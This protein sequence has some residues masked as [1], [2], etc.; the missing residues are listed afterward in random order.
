MSR[1]SLALILTAVLTLVVRDARM[2]AA[3][4][5]TPVPAQARVSVELDQKEFF[6][7]EN[8]LLHFCIENVGTEPFSISL[9][10]DYRG[11]SRSL[12][13]QVQALDAQG[14]PCD[15]PDP[16][17]FC[18]GGL[19]HS[20]TV[21]PGKKHY[22]SIP[23]L[24]YR[25]IEKPGVYTIRVSHDLGWS[26]TPARKVP[27]AETKITFVKPTDEQA[28]KL[29][30]AMLKT[31]ANNGRT[32][33]ER[34]APYPDFSVLRDPV[35]LPV[36]LERAREKSEK[37]LAGIGSI[38]TP[39]A[40]EALIQLAGHEDPAF[41]LSAAQTLDMRLPDPQLFGELPGR[42]PFFNDYLAPRRWL[43]E[44]SWRPRMADDVAD[45]ARKFLAREDRHG[46]EC[47]GYMLQCCGRKEDLPHLVRTLDREIAAAAKRPLE[48]GIYP[49]PRGACGELLRAARMLGAR[50]VPAPA[51]VESAGEAVVYLSAIGAKKDFRPE[52][53]ERQYARLLRHEAAY[54]RETALNNLP[55]PAPESL[56]ELLPRLITDKDV[57]VQIAAC[58][59]AE[60]V[61]RPELKGPVLEALGKAREHWQ[62]QAAGNAAWELG[63][64]WERIEICVNRL[65]EEGMTKECLNTLLGAVVENVGGYSGPSDKWTAQDAKAC[66]ARWVK[67]LQEHGKRLKAGQR[68]KRD[69]PAI[70][71]DLFP[72]ME[73]GL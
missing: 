46:I 66:K 13:F 3:D 62:F 41:A 29:V 15:D 14:K 25:R 57:E 68:F 70:T 5:E 31:P 64:R 63:A 37:A 18:M 20:P 21:Q 16:T 32:S 72:T 4:K 49:R 27:V 7:G 9:G 48:E 39:R 52:G 45:L 12:R 59:V 2:P 40:T 22:E 28:R 67:F 55:L 1:P 71:P 43:V 60:K 56:L 35:Y 53:W 69:D 54:V 19:G 58:H 65:D 8:L 26:E 38:A 6:L 47:G 23:L 34:S 51:K 33:G 44:Q 36:L 30:E 61:K 17:G 11:A 10:G 42:N 50:G 24:R 73:L